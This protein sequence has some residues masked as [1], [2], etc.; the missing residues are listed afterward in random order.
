MKGRRGE[1]GVCDKYTYFFA[2]SAHRLCMEVGL[3]PC[4]PV[5]LVALSA[6]A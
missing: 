1:G 5:F 2:L 3:L 4:A 6:M